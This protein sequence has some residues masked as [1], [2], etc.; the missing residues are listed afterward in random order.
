MKLRYIRVRNVLSFGDRVAELEFGDFNV[1]AGPNDSGKT[2]L[3]RALSLIEK[4][5]DYGKPSLNEILFQGDSDKSLHLEVG[6]ELD[7]T[8]C[9]LLATLIISSELMSI[10]QQQNITQGI[11]D[12]KHWKSILTNYGY[13]TDSRSR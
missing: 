13:C 1:I 4:A 5:F 7:D 6:V 9:E 11:R 12:D 3:F 10:L 2:N 8:E